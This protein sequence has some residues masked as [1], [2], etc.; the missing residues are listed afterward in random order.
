MN[1][2]SILWKIAHKIKRCKAKL[3]TCPTFLIP[4]VKYDP[5]LWH[6]TDIWDRV[7]VVVAWLYLGFLPQNFHL[8][9]NPRNP[10]KPMIT[11]WGLWGFNVINKKLP[12][13]SLAQSRYQIMKRQGQLLYLAFCI[14][15]LPLTLT[16]CVTRGKLFPQPGYQFPRRYMG[17]NNSV[18][19]LGS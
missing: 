2:T 4:C 3:I 7:G 16:R 1:K 6:V 15:I 12:T 8:L 17:N 11:F 13:Q 19:L 9:A 5:S 18:C 10:Q 14:Q